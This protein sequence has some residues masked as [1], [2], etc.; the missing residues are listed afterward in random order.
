M[1]PLQSEPA[2][3]G[4]ALAWVVVALM[5]VALLYVLIGAAQVN[6]GAA[7]PLPPDRLSSVLL[8]I[9]ALAGLGVA[10]YLTY[11]ETQQVSAVCG[12]VGNCN[13]V[14]S[15]PY[16]RLF[17]VL[18]VGLLGALGYLAILV[19]YAFGRLVKGA[20][21]DMASVAILGMAAFGVIFSL[22]LTYLELFVIKAVCIWC[23]SS[24]VIISLILILSTGP[25]LS[26]IAPQYEDVDEEGTEEEAAA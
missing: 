18:P 17:G 4:F 22:W 3:N 10:L 5:L 20:L 23:L 9:L 7:W 25:A 11:V 1:L 8:P 6:R 19:T 16:A 2:N 26:V 21:G 24:A 12:P 13:A 14:Q 15:S